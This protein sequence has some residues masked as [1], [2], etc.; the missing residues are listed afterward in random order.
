[1]ESR[2]VFFVSNIFLRS[3]D[4]KVANWTMTHLSVVA[5]LILSVA[6]FSASFK[7]ISAS[8]EAN[9]A[10]LVSVSFWFVLESVSLLLGSLWIA[11][12]L[13][14]PFREVCVVIGCVGRARIPDASSVMAQTTGSAAI[15]L[16]LLLWTTS[17][18]TTC[19]KHEDSALADGGHPTL[20]DNLPSLY[21]ELTLKS[22]FPVQSLSSL[23]FLCDRNSCEKNVRSLEL[24]T[25]TLY[26]YIGTT[27]N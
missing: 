5:A 25:L 7:I 6:A 3:P 27:K 14:G 8:L 11:C 2:V 1:M 22:R 19:Q 24:F 23:K 17:D 15:L 16:L 26:R 12:L 4:S 21:R 10:G 20:L 18:P 13:I 9:S